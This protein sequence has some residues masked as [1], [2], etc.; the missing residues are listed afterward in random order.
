MGN[1][2]NLPY[3]PPDFSRIFLDFSISSSSIGNIPMGRQMTAEE[4]I[5]RVVSDS[6]KY[7]PFN[8]LPLL[9]R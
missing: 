6:L 1:P 7:S 3:A 8:Y 2:G 9:G 5:R 4:N